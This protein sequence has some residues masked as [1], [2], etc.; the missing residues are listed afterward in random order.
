M[1]RVTGIGGI[2]FMARDPKR[3]S[4]WYRENLGIAADDGHADF[5]WREHADQVGRTVRSVF[6]VESDY[7]GPSSAPFMLNCRVANLDRM[8]EQLCG[9]EIGIEKVEGYDYGRF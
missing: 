8:L 7:F 5:V 2:F 3:L 9:A 4:A 1:E 6:P